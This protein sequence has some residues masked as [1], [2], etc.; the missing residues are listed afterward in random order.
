MEVLIRNEGEFCYDDGYYAVF[1]ET[2]KKTTVIAE[3]EEF[4]KNNSKQ[5]GSVD[6]K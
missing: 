6:E 1:L 4:T 5:D 3:Q 2:P